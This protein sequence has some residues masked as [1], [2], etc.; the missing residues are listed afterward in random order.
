M[1]GRALAI[2]LAS[3]VAS[4]GPSCSATGDPERGA[5][6]AAAGGG[7]GAAGSGGLGAAGGSGWGGDAALPPPTGARLLGTVWGPHADGQAPLFP[8]AGALVAA[9]LDPPAALPTSVAC[10][11][12]VGIPTGI[13]WTTSAADGT[14]H[15]DVTPGATFWLTVQKGQ[16]RRVRQYTAPSA[17]G[18]VAVEPELTSLPNHS[19]VAI[20]D[21]M[22]RIALVYGDYDHIEDVFAKVGLGSEDG[23]YG[24]AWGTEAGHFDVFDN[25][26]PGEPKHGEPLANLLGN[27]ARMAE[28]QVILF[29]CSYNANFAFMNNSGTQQALRDWVW[30]GGKLY[31]SDYAMPVVEM[32]WHDFVWFTNPLSSGCNENAFPPTCN[33]GPP[34]DSKA[35]IPDQPTADWLSAMGQL[36]GL[37][38]KENWNTIGEL[39]EGVVGQDQGGA[40]LKQKPKVWVQGPWSYPKEDLESFGQDPA[41]WDLSEHPLTVTWPY[42]CG[43]VLYTTYHTV[44]GTLGGRHPGLIAQERILF[45][46]LM[47]LTV[48]PEIPVVR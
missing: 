30:K 41:T 5:G 47:E 3:V 33:H 36:S 17:T 10:G 29:A 13:P 8:I 39:F 23:A 4:A 48:C 44:G 24:H 20:G 31:V 34:F 46:L 37:V 26:G 7:A 35:T 2:G 25:S 1:R 38:V 42:N 28:Y 9:F 32:P 15:L 18:E 14:F 19:D 16:F 22:P 11:E 12:C 45:H 21:A 43:R 6:G 27:P 40:P